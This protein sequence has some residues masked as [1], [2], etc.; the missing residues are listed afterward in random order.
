MVAASKIF[1][2][3]IAWNGALSRD[4]NKKFNFLYILAIKVNN[5]PELKTF[6]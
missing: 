3:K 5:F 6:D 2:A 4:R 1:I